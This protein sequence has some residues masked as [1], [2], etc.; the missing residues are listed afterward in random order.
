MGSY[1]VAEV[2][3]RLPDLIT[4]AERGEAVTITRGGKPVAHLK[5]VEKDVVPSLK[6]ADPE[7]ARRIREKFAPLIPY[8]D[9]DSV[10]LL[11]E[12]RSKRD[13]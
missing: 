8:S 7:A 13:F 11:R 1:S 12:M 6:I 4:A 3:D 9:I 5:A 2:Q 10:T